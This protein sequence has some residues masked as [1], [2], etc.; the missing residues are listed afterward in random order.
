MIKAIIFDFDGVLVESTDIKTNAFKKLF[1]E[2]PDKSKE[3]VNYHLGNMGMSR[4]VKFKYF[5]ETILKEPYSD[6]I[7]LELG[8]KFSEIVVCEIKK[9]PTV[10]GTDEFLEE[11]FKKYMFFIASGTPQAELNDIV[12]HRLIDK[13][14]KGI[15]GTP[16]SKTE[17]VESILRKYGLKKNQVVF[18]GD[19]VSDKK[20]SE[21]TGI[22]FILR[23]T[24]ENGD[25]ATK[26]KI[27]NLTLLKRT[28]EQL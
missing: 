14:F 7:G 25:I 5:F 1:S 8:R 15:Y 27:K 11:N 10:K 20:T 12:S 23:V 9:A 16:A 28:I 4:Y 3:G 22:H 17:I 18:V 24:A 19:T 26:H 2:W 13:F 21:D 6:E